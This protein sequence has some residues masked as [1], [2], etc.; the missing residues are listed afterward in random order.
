MHIEWL[1][2]A[3]DDIILLEAIKNNA[4]ITN[5]IAFHSQ[6]VVEKNSKSN[7]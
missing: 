5:M 2:A 7:L 1:K 6:Q 4:Q 3:Y